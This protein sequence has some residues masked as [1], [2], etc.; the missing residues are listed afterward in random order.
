[1]TIGDADLW[2]GDC[3]EILPTLPKHDAVVTDPP[4]GIAYVSAW[5]THGK[6]EMLANDDAAPLDTVGMMARLLSDC[7]AMYLATRF[8]VSSTWVEAIESAGMSVK[9]PIFWDKTNHTS[10]DLIGD[11]G[12]QVEIILYATKGRHILRGGRPSNL[13]R[14]ARPAA[15]DHPTPKPVELMQRIMLHSTD[16]NGFVIDP[17]MGSGTT[18]V[19]CAQ[20]GRKF[21]GIEIE[22]RYFEIACRRIEQA[23]AQGRLFEDPPAKPEQ[24]VMFG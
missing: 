5:R 15:G 8:D 3:R 1:M 19:A 16:I 18:G 6:T 13:W 22:P 21:T 23:Q 24:A 17:F 10:G 20:L 2:L 14:I 11:Y 12:A 4:Y 9:T 7:G